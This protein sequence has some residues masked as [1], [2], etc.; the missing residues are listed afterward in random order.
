MS[1]CI[2]FFTIVRHV[3]IV[4]I[5]CRQ[6][7]ISCRGENKTPFLKTVILFCSPHK[8]RASQNEGSR[9]MPL[10]FSSRL[11]S[12]SADSD[13]DECH[14][15]GGG[16]CSS[17]RAQPRGSQGAGA[18]LRKPRTTWYY[19]EWMNEWMWARPEGK[20]AFKVSPGHSIMSVEAQPKDLWWAHCCT[21]Q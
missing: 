6:F 10:P 21:P 17:G 19:N 12:I 14:V 2:L 7:N 20:V 13:D 1:Y 4:Y 15:H 18:I 3:R 11:P 8:M 5:V 9:L 16:I